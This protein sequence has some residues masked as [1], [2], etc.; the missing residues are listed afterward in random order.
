VENGVLEGLHLTTMHAEALSHG[1]THQKIWHHL[2]VQLRRMAAIA[3]S[4][5][6]KALK[7]LLLLTAPQSTTKVIVTCKTAA[8]NV[9]RYIYR[10]PISLT[11]QAES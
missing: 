10:S 7:G 1:S 6:E 8:E 5:E 9:G 3:V 4:G 2:T 11:D